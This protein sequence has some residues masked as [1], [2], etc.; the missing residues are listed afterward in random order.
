MNH[1]SKTYFIIVGLIFVLL[2]LFVEG[3]YV[4]DLSISLSQIFNTLKRSLL[5]SSSEQLD[6][7]VVTL[8]APRLILAALV[9]ACLAISGAL[10]QGLTRNDL[11]DPSIIGI[12]QGAVM[13]AVVS[14]VV[15]ESISSVGLIFFAFLGGSLASAIIYILAWRSG[16][17]PSRLIL[18]GIGVAAIMH[19]VS[20]LTIVIGNIDNIEQAYFWMSGSLYGT[21]WEDVSIIC[22]FCLIMIPLVIHVIRP[23]NALM[24]EEDK[25]KAIGQPIES[26]RL[27]VVIISVLMASVS[28]A[29]VGGI[30]FIGLVAPHIAR[31]MVGCH[32]ARLLP[33]SAMIGACL[34]MA[35]DIIGRLIFSPNELPAGVVVAIL[36]TP[37]FIVIF[38]KN[39]RNTA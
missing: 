2:A 34:L 37:Y 24:L 30:G 25:A 21:Q 23:I 9:G 29:L 27:L 35:S 15:L 22:V 7:V 26:G 6:W 12:N 33:T 20:S 5:S 8:R 4:G 32:Y 10:I 19:A 14:L 11:A 17:S 1:T 36:G 31:Q 13:M 3:L 39:H 28:V 16:S 38:L 18:V